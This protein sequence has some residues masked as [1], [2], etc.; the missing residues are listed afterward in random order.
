MVNLG[1]E[2]G[3]VRSRGRKE[4]MAAK[5]SAM[6][7]AGCLMGLLLFG[8]MSAEAGPQKT[9]PLPPVEKVAVQPL[10]AQVQR[11]TEAL[12]YLGSPLPPRARAML[13]KAAA[14]TD[15]ARA[16]QTIQ[17]AL[18]PYCLLAV[19]INPESRVKVA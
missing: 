9:P 17:E 16:V 14:E 3:F 5:V 6:T 18:D 4:Q 13:A 2:C 12:D 7:I 15:E 1:G 19:D 8:G 10:L 11:L